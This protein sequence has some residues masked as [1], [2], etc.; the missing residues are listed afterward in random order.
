MQR[1]MD[2]VKELTPRGTSIN[3]ESTMERINLWYVGWANYYSMTQYPSQ[4]AT[5][6]AYVRR[7][8]RSSCVQMMPTIWLERLFSSEIAQVFER[9]CARG[10]ASMFSSITLRMYACRKH[11]KCTRVAIV[12]ESITLPVEIIPSFLTWH[13][14]AG[15]NILS[16]KA[17]S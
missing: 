9:K 14:V 2:R 10:D 1:A 3:I 15:W 17:F 16:F 5:I 11:S 8:L 6:E 13:R 12:A 4:L 7:R